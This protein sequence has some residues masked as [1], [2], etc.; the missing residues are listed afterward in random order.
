MLAQN[1]VQA[2]KGRAAA[3]AV[4]KPTATKRK[5]AAVIVSSE[6]ESEGSQEA[7]ESDS[8]DELQGL[9]IEKVLDSRPSAADAKQQEFLVKFQGEWYIC[10]SHCEIRNKLW[11]SGFVHSCTQ[12]LFS[13]CCPPLTDPQG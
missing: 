9:Q 12:I 1:C 3:K 7:S 5:L 13:Y 10:V 8:E 2:T 11:G 6:S 4:A